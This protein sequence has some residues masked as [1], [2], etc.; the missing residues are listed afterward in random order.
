MYGA[1]S[2]LVGEDVTLKP[3]A[4]IPSWHLTRKRGGD[5]WGN[6]YEKM[7]NGQTQAYL[8]PC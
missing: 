2:C 6:F 5:G 1:A 4:Q 3:E 8:D 7:G